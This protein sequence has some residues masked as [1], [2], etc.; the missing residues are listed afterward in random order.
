MPKWKNI[1]LEGYAYFITTKIK[2]YIK[3]FETK[4]Y[5]D[6]IIDNVNFYREK[7]GFKLWGYVI[8]PEHIHLMIH[9]GDKNDLSKIMEQF[10]RYTSKQMLK[11]LKKDKKSHLIKPF[12]IANVKKEKHMVWEEG[13]RGLGIRSERVFNI[14]MN[15]IHNNPVKRGLVEKP[16]DYTYSSY[17][18]YYC[19]DSSIIKL[20]SIF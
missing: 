12:T 6:I 10:K 7:F 20:D 18:N 14:K 5:F 19:D 15:Y 4:L 3:V 13:F 17:R 2:N 9:L 16:E 1:S 8:M 11:Q